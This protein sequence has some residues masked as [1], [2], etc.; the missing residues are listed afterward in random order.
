MSIREWAIIND[1]FIDSEFASQI[2]IS[3]ADKCRRAG[4]IPG[5]VPHRYYTTANTYPESMIED[6]YNNLITTI[7]D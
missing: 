2:G 1:H 5:Q 7:W 6:E 4:I 3:L